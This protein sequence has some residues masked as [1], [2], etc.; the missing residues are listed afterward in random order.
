MIRLISP[1]A[2]SANSLYLLVVV[3]S[4]ILHLITVYGYSI[5]VPYSDDFDQQFSRIIELKSGHWSWWQ[6]LTLQHNEHRIFTTHLVTLACY[7]LTGEINIRY[8]IVFAAL[9]LT[10]LV[11][12]FSYLVKPAQ[13]LQ[14]CAIASCFLLIPNTAT[15]WLGGSLPYYWVVLF[16]TLCLIVLPNL[17]KTSAFISSLAFFFLALYSLASG[18][19]LIIPAILMLILHVDAS[20]KRKCFWTISALCIIA[21]FFYDY[22]FFD[23]KPSLL[24]GLQNP[25][26]MTKYTALI[27]SN[28]LFSQSLGKLAPI[29]SFLALILVFL[30]LCKPETLKQAIHQPSAY[31]ALYAFGVVALVILG[32][33]GGEVWETALSSRYQLFVKAFWLSIFA[34]FLNLNFISSRIRIGVVIALAMFFI[35][36]INS[37]TQK[38]EDW[39]VQLSQ[40]MSEMI[41][42]NDLSGISKHYG[43][44][45]L[46]ANRAKTVASMGIYHP[47]LI[48]NSEVYWPENFTRRLKPENIRI[49]DQQF[50]EYRRFSIHT[51]NATAP[52][53]LIEAEGKQNNRI[54]LASRKIPNKD[55]YE[56]IVDESAYPLTVSINLKLAAVDPDD[57]FTIFD[58]GISKATRLP[59]SRVEYAQ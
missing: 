31:V 23:N 24:Y 11:F 29:L 51:I 15:L 34:L 16:G 36:G 7:A 48:T 40:D 25:V 9:V 41:F 54:A 5:N 22:T 55:M 1:T 52:I 46:A 8:Q 59:G 33:V 18:I 26:F 56:V 58:V 14:F 39:Q 10:L 27:F 38:L 28:V 32:R 20:A 19:V 50:N 57:S 37:V 17:K 49:V 30:K 43:L 53:L 2:T 21:L 4:V 12:A 3:A 45:E 6:F 13:R 42:S 44:A 35:A 47:E